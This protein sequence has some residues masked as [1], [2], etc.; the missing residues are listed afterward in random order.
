MISMDLSCL[1]PD[2]LRS[3]QSSSFAPRQARQASSGRIHG[4][5]TVFSN[6][7]S[8]CSPPMLSAQQEAMR[9]REMRKSL[10]LMILISAIP[11]SSLC[12][13]S[14]QMATLLHSQLLILIPAGA[15]C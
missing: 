2:G 8:A 11:L 15:T 4:T 1:A 12:L 5:G 9:S 6:F 3:A 7:F 10:F 14:F 13:V